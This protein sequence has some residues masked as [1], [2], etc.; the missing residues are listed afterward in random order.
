MSESRFKH[1]FAQTFAA[2]PEHYIATIRL[3]AARRLLEETNDLVSDIATA[4]G[5]FNQSHLARTFVRER[6]IT[7]G[8]YRRK[9]RLA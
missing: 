5:F 6:G 2:T 8:E 1:V 4:T 9:H 7:P 3:N